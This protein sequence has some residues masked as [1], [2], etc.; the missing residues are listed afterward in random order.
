MLTRPIFAPIA[1]GKGRFQDLPTQE[2]ESVAAW[3]AAAKVYNSTTRGDETVSDRGM[4]FAAYSFLAHWKGVSGRA[5]FDFYYNFACIFMLSDMCGGVP[6]VDRACAS[7]WNCVSWFSWRHILVLRP[8]VTRP[9]RTS[10]TTIMSILSR[11][12]TWTV[13]SASIFAAR[14]VVAKVTGYP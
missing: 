14:K 12:D 9:A 6:Y 1:I 3:L 2:Y 8:L 5:C 13:A 7:R 4:R 11:T 10:T